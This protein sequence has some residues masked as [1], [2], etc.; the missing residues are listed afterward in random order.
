MTNQSAGSG[1]VTQCSPLIGGARL[2]AG[3]IH[4]HTHEFGDALLKKDFAENSRQYELDLEQVNI[5][6]HFYSTINIFTKMLFLQN[7]SISCPVRIIHGL[8]DTEVKAE[9]LIQLTKALDSTDVDLIYRSEN[10]FSV[11]NVV[12]NSF[13]II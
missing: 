12:P 1:H 11:H 4:V 2:E 10:G 6:Y 3:D 9:G 13:I 5:F 7:L 8:K